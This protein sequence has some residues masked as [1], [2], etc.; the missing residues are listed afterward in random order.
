MRKVAHKV[1][2]PALI[3]HSLED[4]ITGIDNATEIYSLL[5]SQDKSI[6]FLTGCDHVITL[7]LRKDVVAQKVG[8]SSP[9]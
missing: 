1:T 2:T 7:D 8:E 4:T 9:A 3:V 5:G 6:E